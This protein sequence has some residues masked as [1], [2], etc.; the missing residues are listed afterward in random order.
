MKTIFLNAMFCFVL[1][2]IAMAQ[3]KLTLKQAIETGIANNIDVKQSDLQ[4][5]KANIN[6]KQSKASMLAES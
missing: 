6:L 2:F 1:H 5:Q 3:N 4:M